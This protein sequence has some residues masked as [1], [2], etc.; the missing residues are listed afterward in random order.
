MDDAL[1]RTVPLWK[2]KKETPPPPMKYKALI[3]AVAFIETLP[4]KL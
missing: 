4:K 1:I 3:L 2:F